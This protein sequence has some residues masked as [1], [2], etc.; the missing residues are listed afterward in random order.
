MS[1]RAHPYLEYLY[2]ALNTP[3]GLVL[4]ATDVPYVIRKL[5]EAD[6]MALE[7]DFDFLIIPSPTT[8]GEIWVLK[9]G[10]PTPREKDAEPLQR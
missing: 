9:N 1:D 4:S 7:P 5:K 10:K 3:E 2:Q 6:A 8:E